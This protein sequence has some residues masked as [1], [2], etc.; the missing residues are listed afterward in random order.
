MRTG[1]NK[2][3]GRKPLS[4]NGKEFAKRRTYKSKGFDKMDKEEAFDGKPLKTPLKTTEFVK[5]KF[6]KKPFGH[7]P[8]E[9]KPFERKDRRPYKS[10]GFD[11]T[12][13]KR[14]DRAFDRAFAMMDKE[15]VFDGKPLKT[16]EF[17][18]HKFDKKPV[19]HNRP[20]RKP[21]G[22]KGFGKPF[23]REPEKKIGRKRSEIEDLRA[24][25][26][27]DEGVKAEQK[28]TFRPKPESYTP[29]PRK[30][31]AEGEK[32]VRLN[33]FIASSGVCSRR[34]ADEFI[35]A[36]VVS[37][38]DQIVT[39]L[40]TKV[41][42]NDVVKF[43]D[44]TIKGDTPVYIIM[45]KPK[46]FTTTTS[47]PH[48]DKTVM[49]LL[50][51]KCSQRVYPIGRLDKDTTGVLLFTNDGDLTERLTHPK[52]EKKKIYQVFLDKK[53]KGTD[54][55]ALLE[56]VDLEDGAI[57]A[58]SLSYIDEDPTQ[59]GIEIHS[60]RNRIVRRMFESLGYKVKK[61]DRVYF[62]GLTKQGLRRG[63]WRFLTDREVAMLKMGS[64]E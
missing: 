13:D 7:K 6:D 17:V 22:H 8:F 41:F 3:M 52:F 63:Q 50:E 42:Q 46:G 25:I 30:P 23:D 34:E 36:G 15:D 5:H 51:G 21:F 62:A 53:L 32:G 57:K 40:G 28:S 16:T 45:N 18:K 2:K 54:F 48:A 10:K 61:L 39:E 12:F 43:N 1:N 49:D 47:D 37:V 14:F 60:G 26:I 20:V 59:I 31:K 55:R 27:E 58:D 24:Q 19:G 9:G 38:N 56:G 35:L 4:H 33:K 11:K 64:Y 29:K 44:E